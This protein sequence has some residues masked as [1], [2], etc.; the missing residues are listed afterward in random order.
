MK[1]KCIQS[2]VGQGA[3]S[4]PHSALSSLDPQ[5][6][7]LLSQALEHWAY[8]MPSGPSAADRFQLLGHQVTFGEV[9]AVLGQCE[10]GCR[11][12]RSRDKETAYSL[13]VLVGMTFASVALARRILCAN[14]SAQ[15]NGEVRDYNAIQ[16]IY[17]SKEFN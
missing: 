3:R 4:V 8:P 15:N 6:L 16:S 10:I 1:I 5:P 13:L 12:L 9:N 17:Y 14:R 2:V 11:Y 7:V